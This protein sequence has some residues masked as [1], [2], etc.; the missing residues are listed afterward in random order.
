MEE[1]KKDNNSRMGDIT[2]RVDEIITNLWISSVNML[3]IGNYRKAFNDLQALYYAISP[4]KFEYKEVL[5]NKTVEL[6]EYFNALAGINDK[7]E[8]GRIEQNKLLSN[9]PILLKDYLA[10]ITHSLAKLGKWL[11][12]YENVPD[13]DIKFSKESFGTENS[14]LEDKKKELAKLPINELFELFSIASIHNAYARMMV[15]NENS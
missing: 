11:R 8:K 15:K 2:E 13:F 6:Q 12:I 1:D 4:Y 7:T 3:T 10:L 14:F 9:I 5:E